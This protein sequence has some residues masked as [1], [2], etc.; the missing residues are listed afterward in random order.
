MGDFVEI[1]SGLAW[2]SIFPAAI[3]ALALGAY[4]L[5]SQQSSNDDD[6]ST[7]GGG[8]MQPVA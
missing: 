8:L 4:A 2:S 7:P 5:W 3:S 1:S 6:D